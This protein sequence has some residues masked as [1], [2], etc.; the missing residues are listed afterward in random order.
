MSMTRLFMSAW[1]VGFILLFGSVRRSQAADGMLYPL[2]AAV[3][4]DGTIYVADR[5]P[6]E[7]GRSISKAPKNFELR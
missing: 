4:E 7:S 1:L 2:A 5:D 3:A 6:M